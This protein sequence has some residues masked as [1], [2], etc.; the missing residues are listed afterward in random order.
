[1]ITVAAV[2]VPCVPGVHA[3]ASTTRLSFTGDTRCT[4][5]FSLSHPGWPKS[6]ASRWA[7]SRP[8]VVACCTTQSC[9]LRRFGEP[10]SRGP[11]TSVNMCSV[12]MTCERSVASRRIF[13]KVSVSTR[14]TA[15]GGGSCSWA[16]DVGRSGGTRAS[17]PS[18]TAASRVV[19][20]PR[21]IAFTD[22]LAR[23]SR[24][25]LTAAPRLPPG[26]ARRSSASSKIEPIPVN[27]PVMSPPVRRRLH[28][29]AH[30]ERRARGRGVDGTKTLL[31]VLR[32]DLQLTGTKHGCELGECG[33]CA[34]LL[35][36]EP[37]LSCLVLGARVRR[38]RRSRPSKGW[39]TTAGSIRCRRRSP[40]S[41]PRSAAT[42]R[43]AFSSPRKALLDREP[44]PSRDADQRGAVR[45][46]VP[47]HR[48]PA[49]HRGGRSGRGK[50]D[51]QAPTGGAMS[52]RREQPT[53]RASSASPRR[54]VDGARQGHRADAASPTTC[55]PAAHAALPAAALDACRTRASC[56][57]T[58][59]A[60]RALA[61]VHLV[62]TGDDFPIPYG[63]LPVSQD[64]HA[65][66]RD[67]VRFVGDPVAAVDRARRADRR[68]RRSI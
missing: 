65:L 28:L 25:F 4:A 9:A 45:Q 39:P 49:D 21:N 5:V 62:L 10:V 23:L 26:V 15:F 68:S 61:G 20:M 22:G 31:E 13:H 38:A 66:C 50:P 40:T 37:V 14:S 8:H 11:Y 59:R 2:M 54:R 18:V 12:C 58:R 41:A 34:V 30:R 3:T 24:L 48:L 47:L 42:A 35:D 1:M 67:K 36:G 64:E 32:E 33:A 52:D 46:P 16:D 27:Q 63:I 29:G 56:G 43:R 57:S 60:R 6:Q 44:H 7:F 17:A 53:T 55:M 51:R 19:R